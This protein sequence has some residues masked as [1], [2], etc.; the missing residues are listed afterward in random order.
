MLTDFLNPFK[1]LWNKTMIPRFNRWKLGVWVI[2][3]VANEPLCKA[4]LAMLSMRPESH[5]ILK[6]L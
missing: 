2:R 4:S 6:S 5:V 1:S 3:P